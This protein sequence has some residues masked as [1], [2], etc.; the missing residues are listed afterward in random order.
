MATTAQIKQHLLRNAS[1]QA[2][3][4][5]LWEAKYPHVIDMTTCNHALVWSEPFGD[6][7]ILPEVHRWLEKNVT[8][9]GSM[10]QNYTVRFANED[11]AFA[12]KLRFG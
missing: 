4:R 8:E 11:D 9:N 6:Y 5:A 1:V 2:K 3:I 10:V 12:F 7:L